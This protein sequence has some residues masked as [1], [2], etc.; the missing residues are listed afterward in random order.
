LKRKQFVSVYICSLF[1]FFSFLKGNEANF[2][3]EK[4]KKRC[5]EILHFSH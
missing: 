2:G 4:G 5:F 1:V 3:F